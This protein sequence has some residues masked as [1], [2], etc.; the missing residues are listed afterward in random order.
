MTDDS[1]QVNRPVNVPKRIWMADIPGG[2]IDVSNLYLW[3]HLRNDQDNLQYR[4]DGKKLWQQL[5]TITGRIPIGKNLDL[6]I[7]DC[8]GEFMAVIEPSEDEG[9]Q[10]QFEVSLRDFENAIAVVKEY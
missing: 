8:Q 9:F 1:C 3:I 10:F 4:I 5:K 2:Y 6:W 7:Y